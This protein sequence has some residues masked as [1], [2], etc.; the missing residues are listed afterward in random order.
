RFV[1]HAIQALQRAN[2]LLVVPAVE[3]AQPGV[4]GKWQ[5]A[6]DQQRAESQRDAARRV[7]RR[8]IDIE[9]LAISECNRSL[10]QRYI[11]RQRRGSPR[12]PDPVAWPKCQAARLT[13]VVRCK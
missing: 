5:I 8:V 6:D 3:A 4:G 2:E 13:R 12:D 7:S 9:T 1:E 10:G 11:V